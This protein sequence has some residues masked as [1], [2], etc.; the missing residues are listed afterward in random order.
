TNAW[1]VAD[2][3]GTVRI[4]YRIFGDHVDGTYM[5]VDTTHAHLNAPAAFLWAAGLE[6]RPIRI[7]FAPPGDATWTVGTQLFPTDDPYTFTAPG[8][9]YFLDSPIE[10][11][12]LLESS[13]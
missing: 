4:V 6:S 9:Q 12:N 5:A 13:F 2:H 3:D 7:T 11:A 1:D 10:L 8:L